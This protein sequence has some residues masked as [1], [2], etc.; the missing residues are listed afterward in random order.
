VTTYG[1]LAPRGLLVN[2]HNDSQSIHLNPAQLAEATILH[3][4]A[5]WIAQ[6][7]GHNREWADTLV[8]PFTAVLSERAGE[9]LRLAYICRDLPKCPNHTPGSAHLPLPARRHEMSR[10]LPA[11]G[12]T[13]VC[14]GRVGNLRSR[15]AGLL[16]H[17]N[18][19]TSSPQGGLRYGASL[20]KRGKG[21]CNNRVNARVAQSVPTIAGAT[22]RRSEHRAKRPPGSA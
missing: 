21:V 1:R 8:E 2:R 6:G 9:A 16:G 13:M 10:A 12:Y 22:H 15:R 7:P 17:T 3:E 18:A 11:W 14:P 20:M 19:L 5:H 4:L